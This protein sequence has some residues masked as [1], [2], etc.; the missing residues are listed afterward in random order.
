MSHPFVEAQAAIRLVDARLDAIRGVLAEFPDDKLWQ[1]PMAG[2]VSLGNL[3]L[4]VAGSMRDWFENGLAQGN[5]QRDR[6]GEFDRTG[7]YGRDQL[8]EHLNETR[9]HCDAWL[10]AIDAEQWEQVCQFRGKDY[11]VREI[12]LQQLVHAAYHAGQAAFLRRIVAGLPP[13]P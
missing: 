7:G 13:K 9:R 6:Q 5:W 12:M 1:R 2:V 4:H 10:Q 8:L 3:V 11:T